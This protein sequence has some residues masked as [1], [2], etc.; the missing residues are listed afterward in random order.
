MKTYFLFSIVWSDYD[1]SVLKYFIAIALHG[2]ILNLYSLA[3]WSAKVF[4]KW[5]YLS[6]TVV[7]YW[8][9]TTLTLHNP[10]L[11]SSSNPRTLVEAQPWSAILFSI[12]FLAADHVKAGDGSDLAY[13]DNNLLTPWP[14]RLIPGLRNEYIYREFDYLNFDV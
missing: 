14:Q 8:K 1:V 5:L 13:M 3:H 12:Q 6:P 7:G 9:A 11:S 10:I 2:N 4:C